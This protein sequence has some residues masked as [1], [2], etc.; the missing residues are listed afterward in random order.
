MKWHF[1][2]IILAVI[3]FS[4]QFSFAK[5]I[6]T[7]TLSDSDVAQVHVALGYSTLLQ[8]DSRPTQAI[9]GDQ[10]S[11]KVEYVGNSIAIKP[12]MAGVST[13]LFVVM[14]YEK[15]NFRITAGRGYEPDYILRI[16][17]KRTEPQ[18]DSGRLTTKVVN[19][20]KSVGGIRFK[21]L[22]IATTKTNSSLI[23]SFQITSTGRAISFQ[24]GDFEI[25]Q[26]GRTLPIENI[27]LERLAIGKGQSLYGMALVRLEN[28]GR[29][30]PTA[31][32]FHPQSLKGGIQIPVSPI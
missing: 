3:L 20:S 14:D 11:F 17:R 6:K 29:K 25:L 30:A 5:G 31:I 24:P 12:L 2:V 7:L 22:S 27:Y 32:R 18:S 4:I 21:L 9:V 1:F 28:I 10:D 16:K 23:Y 13:N 19:A 15:F 8:F 26:N